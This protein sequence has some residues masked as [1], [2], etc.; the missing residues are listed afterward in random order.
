MSR[1]VEVS[2][3]IRDGMLTYPGMAPPRSELVFDHASSR[4]RY[5]GLSEF[6]IA[7][8]HLVGN[9]GTY[10]DAPLHRYPGGADLASLPLDR[11]AD[12]PIAVI[13]T[14]DRAIDPA[15]LAGADLAGHAVLFR[16]GWSQHFGTPRYAQDAPFLTAATCRALVEAG[17]AFVGLDGLNVDDVGD[18][19]RPAHT[20]LLGAGVPVCE[21]MT[22]LGALPTRGGRLHAAP[23]AWVGGASFPVRA[24]VVL[25]D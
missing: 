19:A 4:P 11:L 15:V 20:I 21:H 17:A 24:Y 3:P 12:L 1:L 7:S 2:H 5:G 25:G 16:T 14:D 6:L 8:L 22:N 23:I 13:E 10:V 18:L 9:T